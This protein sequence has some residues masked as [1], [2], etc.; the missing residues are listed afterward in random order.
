MVMVR[1]Y[2][3]W[4]LIV[5][6][7][8]L[9]FALG[10]QSEAVLAEPEVQSRDELFVPFWEVW[11]YI[12]GNYVES[13]NDIE[14]MEAALNGMME[15]LG[16]EHSFYMDPDTF[17]IVNT[18]LEG[19]FEGIGATVRQDQDTGAL[20]IVETIPDSPAESAGILSGDAIVEVDGVDVTDMV[21]SE[22]IG[23]VR[24]P[25][26]TVVNLGIE[27]PGESTIIVIPV[28]RARI[29][30]DSVEARRLED[31]LV[32]IRLMQFGSNT[33]H[34]LRDALI[35]LEAEKSSGLI[36][37]FRGN[38]GGYLTTAVDVA[39]E[40]MTD[41][42]I[43]TERFRNS[44]REYFAKGNAIAPTVPMV[45]LV[46][47][48]SASA[49]E[50]VAGA[51]QDQDRATIV[52]TQTFGKGSV[53]SWRELSNGGGV[54]VT[55]AKWYTPDD[56]TIH[57]VGLTPDIEVS[58]DPTLPDEDLPLRI[59]VEFLQQVTTVATP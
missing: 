21:Q 11:D 51:L 35:R 44:E 13:L 14:L 54:R 3:P 12:R 5:V 17:T 8:V 30:I 24:G 46:D 29:Q 7:F 34:E 10:V 22:I 16:D 36:L 39:S 2:L 56:R 52:G 43:L 59:A 31:G 26:G 58:L 23:R 37:D 55:I 47:E 50:L 32:Y 15:S 25:E 48:G 18:D 19:Q 40:F 42:V 49:S 38:P 1:K 33:D 28:I 41:G 27:R 9:G 6:F 45:V 4:V 57:G 20:V 53:Q